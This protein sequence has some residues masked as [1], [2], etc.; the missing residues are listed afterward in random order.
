VAGLSARR[1]LCRPDEIPEGGARGFAAAPGG[2]MGL[3]AVKRGGIVRVYVN[4]CPH[5]GLPLEMIPN[6]F[7]DAKAE[8]IVCTAHGARFRIEDGFCVSG[9]C[10]GEHLEAVPHTLDAEGLISVAAEAGL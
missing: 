10:Y 1:A 8:R 5:L 2:F 7:L 4:S 3:F 6:R 9:P